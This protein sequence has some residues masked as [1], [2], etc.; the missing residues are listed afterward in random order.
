M[1]VDDS[2]CDEFL[3]NITRHSLISNCVVKTTN[4]SGFGENLYHCSA[5]NL[6][7]KEAMAFLY[8]S[9]L[10]SPDTWRRR[11]TGQGR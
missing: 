3:Y 9:K 1:C 7:L 2:S 11:S 5:K 4:N 6:N 8:W 10:L